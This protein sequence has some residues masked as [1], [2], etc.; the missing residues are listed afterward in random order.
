MLC[1]LK[2]NK[3]AMAMKYG[4]TKGSLRF[5]ELEYLRGKVEGAFILQ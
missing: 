4:R 1:R 3:V 5:Y 2:S